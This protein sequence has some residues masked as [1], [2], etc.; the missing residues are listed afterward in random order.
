[1][2]D[3]AD[4][5]KIPA[6][7]MAFVR[8]GFL[9]VVSE[10]EAKKTV[11]FP[12]PSRRRTH[13]G[14]V[15]SWSVVRIH[16]DFNGEFCDYYDK[17]PGDVPRGWRMLKATAYRVTRR[18]QVLSTVCSLTMKQEPRLHEP[19]LGEPQRPAPRP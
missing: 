3:L 19:A 13:E 17:E 7:V 1:M 4:K 11:E 14:C 12:I 18:L 15:T 2:T 8:D 10:D 16:P 5:Y 9:E 6:E